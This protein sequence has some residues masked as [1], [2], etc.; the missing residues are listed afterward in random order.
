MERE[1]DSLKLQDR[2]QLDNKQSSSLESDNDSLQQS[3]LEAG[4]STAKK[5]S[6]SSF[7][8]VPST[9]R[10]KEITQFDGKEKHR[11]GKDV[12]RLALML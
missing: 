4:Q 8:S 1:D 9:K 2:T 5:R 10:M 3:N 6:R 11:T 7:D 12:H